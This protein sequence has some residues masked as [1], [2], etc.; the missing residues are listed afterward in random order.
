MALARTTVIGHETHSSQMQRGI[1]AVMTAAYLISFLDE[2]AAGNR[3]AADP[4][5]DFVPPYSTFHVGIVNG[6]TAVNIISRECC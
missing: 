6:G 3:A 2:M 1:S 4:G 5:S